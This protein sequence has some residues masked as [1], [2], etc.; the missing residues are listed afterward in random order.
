MAALAEAQRLRRGGD[1]NAALAALTRASLTRDAW[2]AG[3]PLI[4]R[5]VG[6][7]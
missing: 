6:R 3:V 4:V 5:A 2:V 7:M 1:V